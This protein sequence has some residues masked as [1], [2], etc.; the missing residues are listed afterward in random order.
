MLCWTAGAAHRLGRLTLAG[1]F[2]VL[3][4]Q[5]LRLNG[6]GL[7]TIEVGDIAVIAR[8]AFHHRDLFDR[9][10]I[11]QGM[12]ERISIVSVDPAFDAFPIERPW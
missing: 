10:L 4:P 11:A 3:I 5:Q 12:V 6:I 8:L 2:N 9:L 7:L 1:P